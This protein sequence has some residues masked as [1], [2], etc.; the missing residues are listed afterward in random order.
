LE[1]PII[2]HLGVVPRPEVLL[3]T[4]K[5]ASLRQADLRDMFKTASKGV[6]TST[7]VVSPDPLSSTL[8]TFSAVKTP[9]DTEEDSD[10]P[11]PAHEGDIRME[12]T[13]G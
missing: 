6:C 9:K 4:K 1:I 2:W 7:V 12:Y 3:F 13:S 10:G 8:S 5:A 11:E